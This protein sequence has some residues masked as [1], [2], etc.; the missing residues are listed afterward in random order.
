MD[1]D[2]VV[3]ELHLAVGCLWCVQV[4]IA[5][6]PGMT[7]TEAGRVNGTSQHIDSAYDG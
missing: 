1:A 3:E 4:F 7:F 5:R 6:L 2:R